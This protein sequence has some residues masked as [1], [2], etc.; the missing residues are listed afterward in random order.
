[1]SLEK[2][3]RKIVKMLS[4]ILRVADGLDRSHQ[5]IVQDLSCDITQD[6]INIL[7]SVK[8]PS[9]ADRQAA[10]NKSD[11]MQNVFMRNINIEWRM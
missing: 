10:L 9:E 3:E 4:A 5:S 11:L 7:C 8:R 2:S 1:M 6:Q